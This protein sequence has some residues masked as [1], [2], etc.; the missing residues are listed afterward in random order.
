[1]LDIKMVRNE[2]EAVKAAVKK[3]CLDLDSVVDEILSIDAERRALGAKTEALKAEQNAVSK[4]I[5]QLKKEG[6]DVAAVMAEMKALSAKI[7]E[8][9]AAVTELENRQKELLLSLPNLPDP[10]VCAGG[11]ENN[12]PVRVFGE[13]PA[14]DFQPKNHVELCEPRRG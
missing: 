13:K 12:Q 10:D 3:R 14:F 6:G 5:P 2:P 9:G 11:K 7:K 8:D 4:R 1:M